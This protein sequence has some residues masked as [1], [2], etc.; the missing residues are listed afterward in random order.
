MSALQYSGWEED[1]D[2]AGARRGRQYNLLEEEAGNGAERSFVG[3]STFTVAPI[4]AFTQG[5]IGACI[6]LSVC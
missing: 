3:Q 5:V 1:L 2:S 4:T 6:A